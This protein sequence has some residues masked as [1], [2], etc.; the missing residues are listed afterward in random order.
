MP[1]FILSASLLHSFTS[2]QC[3]EKHGGGTVGCDQYW[4]PVN[5][6]HVLQFPSGELYSVVGF[7]CTAVPLG[8]I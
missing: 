3:P 8:D 1:P 2:P 5:I 4:A 6:L 7:P